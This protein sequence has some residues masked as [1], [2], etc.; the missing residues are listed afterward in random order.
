MQGDVLIKYHRLFAHPIL[1][2][3]N[4]HFFE[5]FV[6]SCLYSLSREK[7]DIVHCFLYADAY[8]ASLIKRL[9]GIALVPTL[10]DG[11][12]LYWPTMFGKTMFKGVVKRATRIHAPSEFIR[13]CLKQEFHKESEVIP[14]A[15]NT[16]NFIPCEKKDMSNTRILC[17]AALNVGRKGIDVL[18][19]AF[20]LLLEYIPDATLQL[21]GHIDEGTKKKLLQSVNPKIRNAIEMTGIGR[22][23]DLPLLYREASI[24]VLPSLNECFGMV[25][26]ESL[27]SGTPVVGTRS[28]AIPEIITD[29]NI[30]VLF[31]YSDGADGLCEAMMHCIELAKDP[32]TSARCRAFAEQYSWKVVGPK[33]EQMYY[34]IL[35]KNRK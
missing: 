35:D 4:I 5:T 23:A 22:Q 34:D 7:Y 29:P 8:A 19:N 14:L 27:A 28:G 30:G 17:T 11:I 31:D 12:P 1:S 24:T 18:V 25:T 16:E 21:S 13:G 20:E 3:M 6:P 15:V 26:I 2:R 10:A 9:K 32:E 33:Y